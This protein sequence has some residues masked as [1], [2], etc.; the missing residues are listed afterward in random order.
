MSLTVIAAA[1]EISTSVAIPFAKVTS[2]CTPVT[3]VATSSFS[4]LIVI[5]TLNFSSFAFCGSTL[6]GMSVKFLLIVKS[7]SSGFFSS[8]LLMRP[9]L[10][11]LLKAERIAVPDTVESLR[12]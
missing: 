3:S 12:R 11:S 10:A 1:A 2:P 9:T 5:S 4:F 6:P 8:Y 7:P